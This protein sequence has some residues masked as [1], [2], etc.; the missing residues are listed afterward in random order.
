MELHHRTHV[1]KT[2]I[3]FCAGPKG[4][5]LCPAQTTHRDLPAILCCLC[6]YGCGNHA[7][8]EGLWLAA[9]DYQKPLGDLVWRRE[10]GQHGHLEIDFPHYVIETVDQQDRLPAAQHVAFIR[11]SHVPPQRVSAMR[12]INDAEAETFDIESVE[13]T[14]DVLV[15]RQRLRPVAVPIRSR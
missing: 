6:S 12:D 9:Q 15:K 1:T 7:R 10:L 11:A 5:Y 3:Y 4:V 2:G 8:K 13:T 14:D